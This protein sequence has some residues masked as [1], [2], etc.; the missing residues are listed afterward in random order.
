MKEI[1]ARKVLEQ[2]KELCAKHGLWLDVREV[3]QP[4]LKWIKVQEISIKVDD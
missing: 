4:K 1:E 3:R 2:I